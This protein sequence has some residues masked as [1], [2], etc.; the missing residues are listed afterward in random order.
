[1]GDLS[2]H[3]SRWEFDSHDRVRADPDPRLIACLEKLRHICDDRPLRIVSGYRSPKQ[4]RLVGGAARSQHLYNRAADIPLGY[5][6]VEQALRSGFT[7]IGSSGPWATH[8]DV[9]PGRLA[10]WKYS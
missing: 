9:R 8:V 10:R 4:N 2:A 3:F 5:A 6:T 7:G 1:M